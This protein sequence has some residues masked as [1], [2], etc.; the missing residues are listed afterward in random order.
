MGLTAR[1]E[2]TGRISAGGGFEWQ[3]SGIDLVIQGAQFS[4]LDGWFGRP[5]PAF[6]RFRI[7]MN[8][9]GSMAAPGLS[10]IDMT[11]GGG[12]TPEIKLRGTVADARAA[13]GIDLQL[14]ASAADWW[15]SEAVANAMR[16]PPFR[17]SARL[18]DAP[19]GY[20]VDDLELRI[21][22]STVSASLQVTRDGP[23][24]RVTGKA[25]SPSINLAR[26]AAASSN[27]NAPVAASKAAPGLL[28]PIDYSQLADVDLDLSIGRLVFP[29]GRELQSGKGR[30]ALDNGRLK[31]SALQATVGGAN[32]KLDG[33]IADPQ[34]LSG[35]NLGISLQGGELAD[36]LKFFG[37]S[38]PPLG[39]YQGRAQLRGSLDALSL[40]AIDGTAGRPGQQL[41]VS[42]QIENA[43]TREGMQLA[44]AA[45]I[46]DS[47]AAGR[48]LGVDLPRLPALRAT[49]RFSG[50]QGAYVFDDLRLTLGRT[51]LQGRVAFTPGEPRPRVTANLSGPLVDLSEL[52]SAQAKSGGTSPLLA[53]DVEADIRFDRVVLPDRRALGPVHG[54]IRL[55][56]GAVELKQFSVAV[57]GASA[58]ADG[59]I[60]DPLTLAALDLTVNAKVTHGAGLAAFSGQRLQGLPPFTASGRLTDVHGYA[61]AGLKLD[62]AATTLIG[63][64]AVTRG[65]KRFKVSAKA[66]SPLLDVPALTRPAAAGSAQARCGQRTRDTGCAASA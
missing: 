41:R 45:N 5:L 23:R 55:A 61:L 1:G 46:T 27:A 37:K 38:F 4:D 9:A 18:R 64:V 25:A 6:G 48:L 59:R 14:Q 51:S 30:L 39:P 63:D 66:S 8:L 31:A 10:A 60:N 2:L 21:A 16:L 53:A 56:A 3:S 62:F 44:I 11:V 65:A 40:T 17:A 29:D 52:P 35:L 22:N 54:A 32:I 7:A 36:L 42:G 12:E 47:I 33:I 13:S 28:R 15:R 24:L 20:R 49:A 57:N 43:T 19:Q 50:A 34:K 26:L 58:T